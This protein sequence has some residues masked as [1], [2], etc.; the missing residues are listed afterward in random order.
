MTRQYAEEYARHY[1]EFGAWFNSM[2]EFSLKLDDIEAGKEL[3]R[4]L[5]H[6]LTQVDDLLLI[7]VRQE[8]PDLFPEMDA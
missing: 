4:R 2:S 5:A 8:Y 6:L 7:P 1:R 3:R